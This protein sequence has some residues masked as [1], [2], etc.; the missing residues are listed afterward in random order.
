MVS[1]GF[2]NIH[3]HANADALP[4]AVNV[5]SQGVTTEI[6]NADGFGPIDL[7]AQFDGYQ[8]AGL[9]LNVGGMIGFNSVWQEIMGREDTR[10]SPDQISQMQGLIEAGLQAGAWGVSGGLE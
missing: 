3:S 10:P 1:P 7:S 6:L 9:A 5:L 2:L 8:A 4:S